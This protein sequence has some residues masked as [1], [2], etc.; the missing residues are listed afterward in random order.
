M[1]YLIYVHTPVY[2]V[3]AC[4]RRAAPTLNLLYGAYALV[5]AAIQASTSLCFSSTVSSGTDIFNVVCFLL[6]VFYVSYYTIRHSENVITRA[7][8][9]VSGWE[10]S[11][12]DVRWGGVPPPYVCSRD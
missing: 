2:N 9:F 5:L 10:V 4:V 8:E 6:V 11:R 1:M 12:A 7:G 3:P